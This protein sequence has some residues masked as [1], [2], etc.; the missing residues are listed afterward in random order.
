MTTEPGDE[1]DSDPGEAA[2]ELPL[3]IHVGLVAHASPPS[4]AG[5][6]Y[7]HNLSLALTEIG[8]RVDVIS[9]PPYPELDPRVRLIKLPDLSDPSLTW[10][11]KA[12]W[13]SVVERLSRATNGHAERYAFGRRLRR[14][15]HTSGETYDL[16]HDNQCLAPSLSRLSVPVVTTIHQPL[17]RER[18]IA[19]EAANRRVERVRI[20]REHHYLATQMR[21]AR[22][23][24]HIVTGSV[25]SRRE[26]AAS[27]DIPEALISVVQH[28]VDRALRPL[29]SDVDRN[30][31][32]TRL[33]NES[34]LAGIDDLLRAL[35]ILTREAPE[36]RLS[37]AGPQALLHRC[38]VRVRA[39]GLEGMVDLESDP[40][41]K[42]LRRMY[43][44]AW[45]SVAA[46]DYDGFAATVAE[47]MACGCPTVATEGGGITEVVGDAGIL[48]PN[49]PGALARGIRRLM[50]DDQLRGEL[51]R[52]GRIKARLLDWHTTAWQMSDIYLQTI[53]EAQAQPNEKKTNA[54]TT[55]KMIPT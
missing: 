14:Y 5:A 16:I 50:T 20:R 39:R 35:E 7:L 46:S 33:D 21:V 17:C 10:R 41:V 9:G 52:R 28:G 34:D 31:L 6:L 45:V 18:D 13:A 8:H 29:K 36:L 30:R 42:A 48:V 2:P 24:R 43:A 53:R 27:L 23:A 32:A 37:L 40:D 55:G 44:N 3:L 11:Q 4:S 15:L 47:A 22:H 54:N 38:M 26:I 51:A 12:S 49:E 19:L 25:R 1:Q